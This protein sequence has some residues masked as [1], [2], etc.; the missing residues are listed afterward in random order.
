VTNPPSGC[1]P[2]NGAP[3]SWVITAEELGRT[4][5]TNLYDAIRRLRPAYFET[6][7]PSSIYNDPG[8]AIVIIANRHVI[9]G[10]DELRRMERFGLVCIRRLSATEVS[11]LTGAFGWSAGI[12]LVLFDSRR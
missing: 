11:L 12:E 10:V 3:T 2:A 6:R 9:G 8:D 5:V 4:S 7:G 1:S